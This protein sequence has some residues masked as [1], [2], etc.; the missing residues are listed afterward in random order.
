MIKT[1]QAI[2]MH[3]GLGTIKMPM[4]IVTF[5]HIKQD[6]GGTEQ[7]SGATSKGATYR[8]WLIFL[9]SRG[10]TTRCQSARLASMVQSMSDTHQ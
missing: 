4:E 5:L 8:S 2:T 10:R 7:K 9:T 3:N 6:R 1:S